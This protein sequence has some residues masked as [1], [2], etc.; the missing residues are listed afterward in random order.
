[1][2]YPEN[3]NSCYVNKQIVGD[4]HWPIWNLSQKKVFE[5]S[6]NYSKLNENNFLD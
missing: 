1:M 4:I 5:T 2:D 3:L 6:V